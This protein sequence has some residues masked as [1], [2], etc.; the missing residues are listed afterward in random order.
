MA[1]VFAAARA[2]GVELPASLIDAKITATRSMGE[3][4]TSMHLDMREGRA[5]EIQAILGCP[6]RVAQQAEIAVPKIEGMY[7]LLQLR[8]ELR[9]E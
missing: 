6:M 5:M 3:Y 7:R 1:E 8:D 2:A 4:K 9:G